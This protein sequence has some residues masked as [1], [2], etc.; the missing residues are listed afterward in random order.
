MS[1]KI[2]GGVFDIE[3]THRDAFILVALADH[4]D[5]EGE[6]VYPSVELIAWKTNYSERTVHTALERLEKAR[7]LVRTDG[8]TRD[9]KRP[10]RPVTYRIDLNAGRP[11]PPRPGPSNDRSANPADGRSATPADLDADCRPGLQ[12]TTGRSEAQ[13]SDEPSKNHPL[14]RHTPARY[15]SRPPKGGPHEITTD[16]IEQLRTEID[17]LHAQWW[18]A[19]RRKRMEKLEAIEAKSSAGEA[20][21]SDEK[22]L[23]LAE[24]QTFDPLPADENEDE[25]AYEGRRTDYHVDVWGAALWIAGARDK[26]RGAAPSEPTQGLEWVDVFELCLRFPDVP[27]DK[28]HRFAARWASWA[29]VAPM[30]ELREL[31]DLKGLF[32]CWFASYELPLAVAA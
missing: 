24:G 20:L 31:D 26:A 29:I 13:A 15:R 10:N 4:A 28:L 12:S 7:I 27:R 16:E 30:D 9:G 18:D 6:N 23:W 17:A 14:N 2:M 22:D 21:S 25:D 32:E 1:G 8:T 11:K 5:H 19:P 3:L